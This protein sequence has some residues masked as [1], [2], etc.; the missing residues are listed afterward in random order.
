MANPPFKGTFNTENISDSL[1]G[2]TNTTKS[3]LKVEVQKT[4]DETQLFFDSLM[5]QY[6]G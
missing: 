2:I 5:Q 3:E 1:K 4:L 6:F